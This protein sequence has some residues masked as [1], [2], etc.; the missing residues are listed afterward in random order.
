MKLVKN[1]IF[2][3]IIHQKR[4]FEK[5]QTLFIVFWLGSDGEEI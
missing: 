4:E 2:G 5:F 1:D 3:C